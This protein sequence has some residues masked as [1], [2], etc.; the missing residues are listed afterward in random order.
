MSAVERAEAAV[1]EAAQQSDRYAEILAVVAAVQAA[2]TAAQPHHGCSCNT[3]RPGRSTGQLVAV[4]AG[5][6]A[7][8]MVAAAMF[9]A[10]ALAA[11]GV[12]VSALVCLFVIREIKNQ[13]GK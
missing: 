10:V 13:R 9:L 4:A 7:C 6:C 2:Q 8:G 12:A 3:P 1:V 11:V 5:V